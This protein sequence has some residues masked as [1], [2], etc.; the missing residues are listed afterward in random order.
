MVGWKGGG[1][2]CRLWGLLLLQAIF[3]CVCVYVL[4]EE[5]QL[6][7]GRE[8]ERESDEEIWDSAA[9]SLFSPDAC[10]EVKSR[11][12]AS[13]FHHVGSLSYLT[14]L[15][16]AGGATSQLWLGRLPPPLLIILIWLRG[17]LSSSARRQRT[18]KHQWGLSGENLYLHQ[19]EKTGG[20]R[21]RSFLKAIEMR[22]LED[23][24]WFRQVSVFTCADTFNPSHRVTCTEAQTWLFP[25]ADVLPIFASFLSSQS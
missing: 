8:R 1:R 23:V 22:L 13:D 21:A 15:C 3:V 18:Y 17:G 11:F 12:G 7:R 19:C 14:R 4:W 25:A 2:N 5:R 24:G 6:E 20:A 9:G 16:D 10:H